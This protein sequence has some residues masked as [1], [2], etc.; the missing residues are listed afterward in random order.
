MKIKS[1]F[2]LVVGLIGAI[3][4]A[5]PYRKG[6]AM[7]GLKKKDAI[8]IDIIGS[9]VSIL[10]LMFFCYENSNHWDED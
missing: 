9:T 4:V 8:A 3:M 5:T 6:W 1:G 10:N 2:N 7:D